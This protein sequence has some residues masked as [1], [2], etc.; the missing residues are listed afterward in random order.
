MSAQVAADL[1]AAAEVL[2]RDGWTQGV[3]HDLE[4]GCR[5]AQGAL[6]SIY[7]AHEAEGSYDQAVEEAANDHLA[8][9]IGT[10]R[11]ISWNDEPGRTADEVIAALRAAADAAEVQ[12]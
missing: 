4:S 9:V 10:P 3:Y 1:R 8:A 5:C 7:G 12:G 6:D 11:I 2:E